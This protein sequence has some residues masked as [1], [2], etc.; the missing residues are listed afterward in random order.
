MAGSAVIAD[1]GSAGMG[2]VWGWLLGSNRT[3]VGR[4]VLLI[5]VALAN[6]GLAASLGGVWAALALVAATLVGAWLHVTW[7]DQLR[8]R[9][10]RPEG[11][12]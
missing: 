10:A 5:A 3:S 12:D 1:V 7:T 2:L 4:R 9:R 8:A 11:E 6:A